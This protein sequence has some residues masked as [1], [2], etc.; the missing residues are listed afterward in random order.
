MKALTRPLL[1]ASTLALGACAGTGDTVSATTAADASM[2]VGMATDQHAQ[3][4]AGAATPA[5]PHASAAA[6]TAGA[7]ATTR[8]AGW[9]TAGVFRACG[10]AQALK[11]D[12]A[13]EIDAQVR[14]GGMSAG[15]PVYVEIEGMAMG[16]RYLL[17]RVAQV[18]STAPVRN[19]AMTGT[20]T[21]VGG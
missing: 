13:A 4:H 15:D 14:K 8:Q 9:Y 19:C 6:S 21:Q 16:D 20:T 11:V 5:H 10:S 2:G 1:L 12:R 7:M 17:K 18:G 3:T